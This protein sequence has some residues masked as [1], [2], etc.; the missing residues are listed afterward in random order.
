MPQHPQDPGPVDRRHSR[1]PYRVAGGVAY[2]AVDVG[3]LFLCH[4]VEA[5]CRVVREGDSQSAWFAVECLDDLADPVAADTL[6]WCLE[7]L[8]NEVSLYEAAARGLGRLKEPRAFPL[9]INLLRYDY[10]NITD[11]QQAAAWALGELG[12]S[13]AVGPLIDATDRVSVADA[14]LTALGRIG[15]P[16]AVQKLLDRL[17]DSSWWIGFACAARALGD[18]ADPRAIPALAGHR[19][20]SDMGGSG[21]AGGGCRGCSLTNIMEPSAA[22]FRRDPGMTL[23]LR[24][25]VVLAAVGALDSRRPVVAASAEAPGPAR[26]RW[27]RAVAG[28]RGSGQYRGR[29]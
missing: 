8:G 20:I 14:A 12:D 25:V 27:R 29:W 6:L 5:L 21:V 1:P 18:L 10:T 19:A 2:P 4:E 17:G 3:R 22:G 26:C 15:S 16:D 7:V 9:L 23:S 28:W 11:H 13:R 24:P